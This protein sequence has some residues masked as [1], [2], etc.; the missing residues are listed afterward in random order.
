MVVDLHGGDD[1]SLV[2]LR[3]AAG[4]DP[5]VALVAPATVNAA[6]DTA[7]V[8]VIPRTAPQDAATTALVHRLR[9]TVVPAA[10]EGS[11][12]R[13]YVERAH[14]RVHRICPT[15]SPAACRGSSAPSCGLSFLLLMVVFRSILVPLKA[16]LMNLLSIGAAYGVIVAV[17]QWGWVQGP[18]RARGDGADRLVRAR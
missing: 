4:A 7:V 8:A 12:A 5:N 1:G 18:D 6:G 16:A 9:R 2:A 13:A 11:D 17:F 15:R 3:D 10:L 14:R